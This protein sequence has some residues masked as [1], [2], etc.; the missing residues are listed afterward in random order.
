MSVLIDTS[1]LYA[2]L[3]PDDPNHAAAE[4]A[5]GGLRERSP[6]VT[7]SYVVVETVALLQHRFGVAAVRRLVDL[8]G[9]VE[10]VW[11]GEELHKPALAALLAAPSPRISF[12]DRVSFELMRDRA[13]AEAFAFDRDFAEEGFPTIP[14]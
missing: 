5:F 2:L 8:L 13:I 10:V 6:L 4:G 7:H 1:A 14:A 11:V 12:V 9:P 3:V